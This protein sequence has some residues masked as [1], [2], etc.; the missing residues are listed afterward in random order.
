MQPLDQPGRHRLGR[1]RAPDQVALHLVAAHL[2]QGLELGRRL[3]A[4]GDGGHRQ[5]AGHHD[6]GLR[7]RAVLAAVRQRADEGTVDLQRVHV[8]PLQVRER[9]VTG[10]EVVQRDADADAREVGQQGAGRLVVLHDHRLGELDVQPFGGDGVLAQ[11]VLDQRGQVRVAHLP[12]RQVDG[13]AQRRQPDPVPGGELGARRP[14]H[15]GADGENEAGLLQ[16]ADEAVRRHHAAPGRVPAQ[17]RLD[18]GDHAV[19]GA[20]LRLVVQEELA[21]LDGAAQ[22]VLERKPGGH[23][24]VQVLAEEAED[25]AALRLGAVH[26][27]V[28]MPDEAVEIDAVGRVHRDADAGRDDDLLLPELQRRAQGIQQAL[29][30]QRGVVGTGK[31]LGDDGELVAAEAGD[32]EGAVVLRP[33]QRVDAAHAA[34]QERGH[35][36][37]QAVP[38]LV[39]QAVVH[40]LE[41]IEVEEHQRHRASRALRPLHGPLQPA[42]EERA[43]GQP[44]QAVVVGQAQQA[45][46]RF[47]AVADVAQAHQPVAAGRGRAGQRHELDLDRCRSLPAVDGGLAVAQGR[48]AVLPGCLADVVE[49]GGA[50]E[51]G[52]FALGQ[53]AGRLVAGDDAAGLIAQQQRVGAARE[54]R[55]QPTFGEVQPALGGLEPLSRERGAP[56]GGQVGDP[57]HRTVDPPVQPSTPRRAQARAFVGGKEAGRR[58]GS[59]ISAYRPAAGGLEPPRRRHAAQPA[60]KAPGTHGPG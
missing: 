46:L 23:R 55:V 20:C 28:G 50:D 41:A 7:D 16:H 21:A 19:G 59:S 15:P 49:A 3:H 42:A 60:R 40:D 52:R 17:Q 35:V 6:D 18:A 11:R 51:F 22:R 53:P 30:D 38:R 9:R 1:Q 31:V 26:R 8:E 44:G 33:R 57:L 13:H 12:R 45:V 14:D 54:E 27:H 10:A 25:A 47:A 32:G 4:F 34:G 56:S 2:A 39:A 48:V 43:V 58:H 36:L 5:A 24:G 37:Q 29:R